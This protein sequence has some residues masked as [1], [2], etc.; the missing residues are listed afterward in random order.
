MTLRKIKPKPVLIKVRPKPA[1]ANK[2]KSPPMSP[3]QAEAHKLIT[4]LQQPDFESVYEDIAEFTG[5]A[6]CHTPEQFALSLLKKQHAVLTCYP[7]DDK[8]TVKLVY[9][10][11]RYPYGGKQTR[12]EV[13]HES[14]WVAVALCYLKLCTH[15]NRKPDK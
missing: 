1:R 5:E 7:D 11:G 13:R 3:L 2:K 9:T 4:L 12:A 6:V 10:D 8:Y 15:I 14:L